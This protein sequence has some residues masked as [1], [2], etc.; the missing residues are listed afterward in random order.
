MSQPLDNT[1]DDVEKSMVEI[2]D[3]DLNEQADEREHSNILSP[4]KIQNFRLLFGGQTISALGDTF[5]A[6]AL[7]WLILTSGGN[8]QELGVLLM[9]YGIPRVATILLGGV[10]SDRLRPRWVMLLAD[11]VR[12]LLVGLL[13]LLVIWKRSVFWQLL[14]IAIPLGAFEGL[15]LPAYTSI[16]PDILSDADLQ[17]GNSLDFASMQLSNLVGSAIAGIIVATLSSGVALSID[18]ITFAVSAISL[19]AMRTAKRAVSIIEPLT[20]QADEGEKA[21][22][23]WQVVRTSQFIQVAFVV[24]VVANLAFGGMIEVALP[25][26]ARGPLAAG[27]S[28]FGLM[29]SA[30]GGGALLG[31]LLIGSLGQLRH[32]ALIA[33]LASLGQALAFALVPFCGG[34]IGAILCLFVAGLT[35]SVTNVLFSTLIQQLIPR[36]LLGR[37]MSIFMLAS[38]GSYPL[39]VLITGII[40]V[41]TGPAIFFPICGIALA[42]AILYGLSQRE[43]REL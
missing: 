9:S 18:A 30:F 4:F 37:I 13:A 27:A 1:T 2:R 38:F 19:A 22:T 26:L 7:P 40:V 14:A 8:A 41:H 12:T 11:I 25:E 33:L 42:L 39:S 20:E 36:H 17:A 31:S 29:L 23:F 16:L 35:N 6:V 10:L 34:L 43:L 28:G 32:R 5:Y 24:S 21:T 3:D 15:F